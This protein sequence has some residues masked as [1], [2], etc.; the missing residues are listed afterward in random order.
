MGAARITETALMMLA[1]TRWGGGLT[2]LGLLPSGLIRGL[3]KGLVWS[4]LFGL[5]TLFA[6]IALFLMDVDPLHLIRVHTP[7]R[8]HEI[9]L[10]LL[11]AGLLGPIA[12]EVFFRGFVYG[13]LRRWGVITALAGSTLLFVLAHPQL[14][15]LPV[16]QVIGG[17]IFAL[18]YEKEGSLAAPVTIHVLGNLALLTLSMLS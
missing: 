6:F 14:P 2:S 10:Y 7:T 8:P 17:I 18:A 9:V 11:V 13:Y 5:A 16:P 12:E 3:R 1:V 4:A 15:A